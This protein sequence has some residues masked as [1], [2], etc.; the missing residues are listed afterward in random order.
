[1]IKV[2]RSQRSHDAIYKHRIQCKVVNLLE[3]LSSSS[4]YH[5]ASHEPAIRGDLGHYDPQIKSVRNYTYIVLN[6][7]GIKY[8]YVVK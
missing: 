7:I 2:I 1:M 3:K 8:Y 6:F 4:Y 5:F